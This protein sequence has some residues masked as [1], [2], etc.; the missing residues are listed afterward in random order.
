MRLVNGLVTLTTDFGIG[1][2]YTGALRG[3]VLR[4][5]SGARLVDITHAIPPQDVAEAADVLCSAAPWFPPGT[6]HLVVVDPGVGT[7]RA[8]VAVAAGDHWLVGPDNGVLAPTAARLGAPRCWR[9]E[10]DRVTAPEGLSATFHGRDLFGPVAGHLAAGRAIDTLALPHGALVEPPARPAP[11]ERQGGLD[12]VVVRVDH[13][14]NL[15]TNLPATR[16]PA[17]FRVRVAGPAVPFVRTYGEAPPGAPIVALV[18]SD[19]WLELAAP[20]GSAARTLGAGPGLAV[21]VE[22]AD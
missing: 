22:P 18:G 20:N 11:V 12:G 2:A 5:F 10:P 6:V 17:S 3:S 13:F 7:A 8:P 19:G 9:L 1:G 4:A 16:L 15:I 21:R 14:G